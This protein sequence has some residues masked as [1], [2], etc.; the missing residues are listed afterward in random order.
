MTVENP[1][2]PPSELLDYRLD[3]RTSLGL[4]MRF[5]AL[6]LFFAGLAAAWLEFMR[7][8]SGVVSMGAPGIAFGLGISAATVIWVPANKWRVALA[9]PFISLV[10]FVI[11]GAMYDQNAAVAASFPPTAIGYLSSWAVLSVASL[12]GA[13]CISLICPLIA[14]PKSRSRVMLL[15]CVT[16]GL[17]GLAPVLTGTFL[18]QGRFF[19]TMFLAQ[20]VLFWMVGWI[21]GDSVSNEAEI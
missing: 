1:Y 4:A 6:G 7:N 8:P 2:Q 9:A 11:I 14:R 19:V 3:I 21:V 16:A 15:V 5:F 12:P 10:G 13:F 17:A 18:Q 20:L